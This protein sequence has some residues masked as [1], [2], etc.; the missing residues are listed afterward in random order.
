MS[1]PLT[2][3]IC[4]GKE[5]ENI[6][7]RTRSTIQAT[8]VLYTRFDDFGCQMVRKLAPQSV[9]SPLFSDRF[10]CID[11]GRCL[12]NAEFPGKFCVV[13]DTLPNTAMVQRELERQFPS[14]DLHVISHDDA[15]AEVSPE[16]RRALA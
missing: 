11:V 3:E 9:L 12:A 15:R 13:A 1:I 14:R 16:P 2:L 4:S 6:R 5:D 7:S 10:D 8:G